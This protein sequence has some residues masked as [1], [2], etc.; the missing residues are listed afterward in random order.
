MGNAYDGDIVAWAAEQAL[1]KD[2]DNAQLAAWANQLRAT[3]SIKQ[4]P[5][6]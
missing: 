3:L 5:A 1:E 6:A 2:P 4:P